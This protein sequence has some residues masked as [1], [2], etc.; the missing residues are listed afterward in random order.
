MLFIE[1]LLEGLLHSLLWTVNTAV[2]N[3]A[4]QFH[5]ELFEVVTAVQQVAIV[6]FYAIGLLIYLL[7]K[8]LSFFEQLSNFIVTE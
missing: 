7:L 2:D 8:I 5:L 3:L 6:Q 1:F 4:C